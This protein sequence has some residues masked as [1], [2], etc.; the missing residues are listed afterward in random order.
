MYITFIYTNDLEILETNISC[1]GTDEMIRTEN[2]N[3]GL[4]FEL[5]ITDGKIDFIELATLD[6][7]W[8]G[9]ANGF[10]FVSMNWQK[11]TLVYEK[12]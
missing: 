8:D 10:S 1:L 2:L 6:E 7:E 9:E 11:N 4:F 3:N 12:H 5:A